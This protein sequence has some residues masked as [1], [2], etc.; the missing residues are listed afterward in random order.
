MRDRVQGKGGWIA[1]LLIAVIGMPSAA[2]A[3]TLIDGKYI[4]PGTVKARQL[5]PVQRA[6]TWTYHN[7][8]TQLIPTLL[9]VGRRRIPAGTYEFNVSVAVNN[10]N[11]AAQFVVCDL[12]VDEPST[13]VIGE[14]GGAALTAGAG[15]ATITT[16]FVVT[17]TEPADT[18]Q[19]L[20]GPPF[21]GSPTGLA[22]DDVLIVVER[23][24][25]NRHIEAD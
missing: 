1:A 21:G 7:G 22:V 3:A 25:L 11:V 12:V 9:D 15:F 2:V 4:K 24:G 23:T 17:I 10:S 14:G 18:I 13:T 16:M 20:C 5:D 6:E 19:L 8:A